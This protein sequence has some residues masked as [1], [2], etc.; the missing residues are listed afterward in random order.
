MGEPLTSHV[1][2]HLLGLNHGRSHGAIR[3]QHLVGA[4]DLH[5]Q[6]LG[7][8]HHHP[9]EVL[10]KRRTRWV[11][12]P[13]C[14]HPRVSPPPC[15]LAHLGGRCRHRQHDR[16]LAAF[17]LLP[18]GAWAHRPHL[19]R[20]CPEGLRG[21]VGLRV[22]EHW[23]G[24]RGGSEPRR[25]SPTK[26]ALVSPPDRPGLLQKRC[27]ESIASCGT[28]PGV[29]QQAQRTHHRREAPREQLGDPQGPGG[30]PSGTG[31]PPHMGPCARLCCP[32]VHPTDPFPYPTAPLPAH[33]PP[34]TPSVHCTH[35]LPPNL[36]TLQTPVWSVHPTN[37]LLPSPCV[38]QT[39]PAP[40]WSICPPPACPSPPGIL[41]RGMMGMM[42]DSTR[43]S[44]SGLASLSRGK[45]SSSSPSTLSGDEAGTM[46]SGE[47]LSSSLS[48]LQGRGCHGPQ[49]LASPL[50]GLASS[51]G[52]HRGWWLT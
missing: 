18:R 24:E 7:H 12:G 34:P 15:P 50:G 3:E 52:G 5:A 1:C 46:L 11:Q 43:S 26:Q 14:H 32:A 4:G 41:A 8:G 20:G 16:D 45:R 30:G 13:G 6:Q 22:G 23:R 35:P 48:I 37:P 39:P 51:L 17:A 42:G 44:S 10:G 2:L 27:W 29:R 25:P 21:L 31:Q 9:V 33:T 36:C 38:A 28:E 47:S 40:A 19:P 49:G